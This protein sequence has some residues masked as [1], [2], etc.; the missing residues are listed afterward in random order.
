MK[1]MSNENPF[2]ILALKKREHRMLTGGAHSSRP[3]QIIMKYHQI[4]EYIGVITYV[5]M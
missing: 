4:I 5:T 3:C 1:I 2:K